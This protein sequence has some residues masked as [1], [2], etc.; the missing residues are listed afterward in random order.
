VVG[1]DSLSKIA[2]QLNIQGG[3]RTRFE[4]NKASSATLT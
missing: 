1:G 3:W 4:K 2:Q